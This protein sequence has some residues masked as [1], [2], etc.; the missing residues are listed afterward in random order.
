MALHNADFN[1]GCGKMALIKIK[2]RPDAAL[3]GGALA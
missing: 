2:Q 3:F 1:R